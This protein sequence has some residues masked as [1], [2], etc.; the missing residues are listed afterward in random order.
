MS[1]T[2]T[3]TFA[4][5]IAEDV[6]T[7]EKARATLRDAKDRSPILAGLITGFVVCA[8]LVFLSSESASPFWIRLTLGIAGVWAIVAC[9]VHAR[10]YQQLRRAIDIVL[11]RQDARL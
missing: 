5:R 2:A 7:Y 11:S 3:N 9:I 4:K 1:E 6:A 8:A 10:K